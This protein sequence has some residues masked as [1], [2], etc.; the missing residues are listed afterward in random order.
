MLRILEDAGDTFYSVAWSPDSKL[1]TLP[2]GGRVLQATDAVVRIWD[3]SSSR[4][5]HTLE[6]HK[7]SSA[8]SSWSP[9]GQLLAVHSHTHF[10]DD[11]G[12]FSDNEVCIWRT[13]TWGPVVDLAVDSLAWHPRLT[14][15][16]TVGKQGDLSIWD[17][18]LKRLF[19][20]VPSSNMVHY[21]NAKVVLVGDSGVGKSGLA[22]VLY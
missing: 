19:Q 2:S 7:A 13:D 4:L 6:H 11:H 14:L 16:A 22:L 1:L 18:D 3:L 10:F 20:V 5:L 9:D 21:A 8:W 15:M 17:L 12:I